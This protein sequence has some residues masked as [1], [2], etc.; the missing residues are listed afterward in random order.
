M[1]ADATQGWTEDVAGSLEQAR[2][3]SAKALA[4]DDE[5]ASGHYARAF[6]TMFE[7]RYAEARVEAQRAMALRPMCVGPRAGAMKRLHR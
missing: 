7:G 3:L 6:V 5:N 1:T 2:V 4:L